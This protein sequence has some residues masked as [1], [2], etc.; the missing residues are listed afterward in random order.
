MSEPI[1][2]CPQPESAYKPV[3]TVHGAASLPRRRG[4]NVPN[5]L[6]SNATAIRVQAIKLQDSVLKAALLAVADDL[7][8]MRGLVLEHHDATA[9]VLGYR[10]DLHYQGLRDAFARVNGSQA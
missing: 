2:D 1:K 9:G 3:I 7:D 8:E 6:R 5:R 4:M 10:D